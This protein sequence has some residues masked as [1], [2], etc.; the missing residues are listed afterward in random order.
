MQAVFKENTQNI[1]T[2]R[3]ITKIKEKQKIKET[4]LQKLAGIILI[5]IGIAIIFIEPEDVTA[6]VLIIPLGLYLMFT[7]EVIL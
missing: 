1:Y 7:R 5:A 4:L 6:C 3:E 2:V